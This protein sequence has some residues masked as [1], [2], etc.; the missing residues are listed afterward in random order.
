MFTW[1]ESVNSRRSAEIGSCI[2]QHLKLRAS[3]ATNLIVFSDACGGQNRNIYLACLWMN[4]VSSSE[5]N[6]PVVDHKFMVS[7]HS[8]LPYDRDFGSIEMQIT[9]F[10]WS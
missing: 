10:S 7:G 4:A 1:P 2:L 9:V 8:Y 3:D 5:F 6:Y